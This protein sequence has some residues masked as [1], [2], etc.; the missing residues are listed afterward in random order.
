M[1]E[2]LANRVVTENDYRANEVGDGT[3]IVNLKLWNELVRLAQ[4]TLDAE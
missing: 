4:D 2:E 3:V 1:T